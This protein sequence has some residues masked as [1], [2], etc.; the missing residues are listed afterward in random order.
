MDEIDFGALLCARLCHDLIS[1]V[2][3]ARNGIAMVQDETDPEMRTDAMALTE[4]GLTDAVAKLKVYRIAYGVAGPGT[5]LAEARAAALGLFAR[6]RVSVDWPEG[7]TDPGPAGVR[8]LLNLV[9]LGADA[10]AR[11]GTVRVVSPGPAPAIE[12]TGGRAGFAPDVLSVLD[13]ETPPEA[14][15]PRQIQA[16][17]T[18]RLAERENSTIAHT[19]TDGAVSLNVSA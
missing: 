17:L 19:A 8:L 16:A 15:T 12:A 3:A 7:G 14:L 11:G 1:P 5:A 9:L 4:D 18:V 10:V 13:G 6:G 2:S